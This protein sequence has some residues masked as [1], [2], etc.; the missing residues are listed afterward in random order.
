MKNFAPGSKLKS[1]DLNRIQEGM[2][3]SWLNGDG[4]DTDVLKFDLTPLGLITRWFSF[5]AA[6]V[7]EVVLDDELD[8]RDRFVVIHSKY[9]DGTDIRP[10]GPNDTAQALDPLPNAQALYTGPGSTAGGTTYT[11]TQATG[12]TTDRH[13]IYAR[14]SDGALVVRPEF[15]SGTRYGW[16][17]IFSTHD[18]GLLP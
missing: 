3:A 8:W 9:V 11:S 7:T 5:A 17:V 13:A 12:G 18:I 16:G 4:S 6:N 2:L 10:G 15:I 14:S 1:R